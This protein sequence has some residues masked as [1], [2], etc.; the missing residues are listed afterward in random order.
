MF[1]SFYQGFLVSVLRYPLSKS[2]IPIIPTY[3]QFLFSIPILFVSCIPIL[4]VSCIP[5]L[6]FPVFPSYSIP[7]FSSYSFPV[8]PSCSCPVFPSR[9]LYS[10][11]IHLPLFTFWSPITHLPLLSPNLFPKSYLVQQGDARHLSIQRLFQR[12]TVQGYGRD[13]YHDLKI[14]I[15]INPN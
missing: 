5:I 3:F 4:L 10:H 7:V 8:F 2:L 14:Y 11:L 9:V 13:Q 6:S 15:T 1:I 12:L